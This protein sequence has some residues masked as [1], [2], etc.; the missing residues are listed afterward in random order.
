MAKGKVYLIGFGPGDPEL[1]TLKADRILSQADIIYHDALINHEYLSKYLGEKYDVGKRKNNHKKQQ[2]EINQLLYES[3]LDGKTVVR[4][5]G[6][7]PMIF[8]RGLEELE[9]LQERS[10]HVEIIPG[11][12]SGLAAASLLKIPL[13]KRN[14]SSS[15]V[16][17]TGHPESSFIA[18]EPDSC[19]IILYMGASNLKT[20]LGRL[21]EKGWTLETYVKLVS[22]V[23]TTEQV[24]DTET[25]QGIVHSEVQYASPLIVFIGNVLNTNYSE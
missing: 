23:S 8:S 24:V 2:A 3:A 11:I 25:I 14:I 21:I 7:D 16:F 18:P 19:T 20:I 15:I 4:L 9:F 17:C 13:T 1:L 6:G 5:K 10:V 22:N 12:T